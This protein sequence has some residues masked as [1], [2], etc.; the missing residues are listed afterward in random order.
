MKI[1]TFVARFDFEWKGRYL[2]YLSA[3]GTYRRKIYIFQ[4]N[5]NLMFG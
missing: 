3:F 1:S 4:Y 2:S 5:T